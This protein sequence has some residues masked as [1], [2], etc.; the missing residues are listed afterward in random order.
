MGSSAIGHEF[1][2]QQNLVPGL[3]LLVV[4]S[5]HILETNLSGRLFAEFVLLVCRCLI[6]VTLA[7][8]ELQKPLDMD[9]WQS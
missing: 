4:A 7:V 8:V 2:L 5:C 3:E 9:S 6:E 1:P